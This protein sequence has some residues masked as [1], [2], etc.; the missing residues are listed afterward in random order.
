M[1]ITSKCMSFTASK[2]YG[3]YQHT[4]TISEMPRHDHAVITGTHQTSAPEKYGFYPL[5]ISDT[6]DDSKFT[7]TRDKGSSSPH[8]N[9]Q[10]SIVVFFWQR[11]A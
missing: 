11:T 10:P 3:E 2:T 4:L 6:I 9:I 8:N 7:Y 1:T 5:R